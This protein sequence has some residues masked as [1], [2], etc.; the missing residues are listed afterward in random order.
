MAA[1]NFWCVI[2]LQKCSFLARQRGGSGLLTPMQAIWVVQPKCVCL[3]LTFWLW[4]SILIWAFHAIPFHACFYFHYLI[5]ILKIIR[6]IFFAFT[7]YLLTYFVYWNP[8]KNSKKRKSDTSSICCL[9]SY[10][11]TNW[12]IFVIVFWHPC[13]D[14]NCLIFRKVCDHNKFMFYVLI[15]V[16]QYAVFGKRN[17]V[18][19]LVRFSISQVFQTKVN[20]KA[21]ASR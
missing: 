18:K 4:L 2:S 11:D 6:I 5:S 9:I 21:T 1:W 10:F 16:Y 13:L 12:L 15:R 3:F 19:I 8:Q 7:C 14:L 17:S 20:L